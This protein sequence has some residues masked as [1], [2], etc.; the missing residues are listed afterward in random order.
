MFLILDFVSTI[1]FRGSQ[2]RNTDKSLKNVNVLTDFLLSIVVIKKMNNIVIWKLW[3]LVYGRYIGLYIFLGFSLK[4]LFSTLCA[5]QV[6]AMQYNQL[7]LLVY[8]NNNTR[9]VDVS[10]YLAAGHPE[11]K[12]NSDQKKR[13]LFRGTF[14]IVGLSSRQALIG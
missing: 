1:L 10:V 8:G 11:Y 9:C 4:L 5:Q 14:S 2:S 12:W 13:G 7:M 3:S 6:F